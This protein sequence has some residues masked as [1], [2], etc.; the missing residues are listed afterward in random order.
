M[1]GAG[2]L[3]RFS[4]VV[5]CRLDPGGPL[6]LTLVGRSDTSV[7]AQVSFL[8]P[9][10]ASWPASLDSPLVARA[11]TERIVVK[12]GAAERVLHVRGVFVHRDVTRAFERAVPP[13]RAPFGK[14]VFWRLVLALAASRVGGRVR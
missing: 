14:R 1:N 13:R 8:C 5:E 3:A 11:D 7:P 9:A 10:P 2:E 4:G 12:A 6:G